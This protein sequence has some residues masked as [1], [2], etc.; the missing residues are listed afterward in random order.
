MWI[1]AYAVMIPEHLQHF[2]RAGLY[3][4][5]PYYTEARRTARS[6]HC[7]LIWFRS[8][9]VSNTRGVWL[10]VVEQ[11]ISYHLFRAGCRFIHIGID[12]QSHLW[13]ENRRFQPALSWSRS[14]IITHARLGTCTAA[15]FNSTFIN[16]DTDYGVFHTP[17]K[18]TLCFCNRSIRKHPA[19]FQLIF[20]NFFLSMY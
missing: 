13:H 19:I 7:S 9:L 8:L 4:Y 1:V 18:A 16:N 10:E 12:G 15:L 11:F 20:Q 3:I 17:E 5:Y 14:F 6:F 2:T